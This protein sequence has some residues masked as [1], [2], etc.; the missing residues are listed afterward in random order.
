MQT[1]RLS[2]LELVAQLRARKLCWSANASNGRA[3]ARSN[4]VTQTWQMSQM[5]SL[6][7]KVRKRRAA[8]AAAAV[9][10]AA[11]AAAK[12]LNLEPHRA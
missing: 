3:H 12:T 11:A 4:L 10:A 2:H 8:A 9:A 5:L 6:P 7:A 1:H